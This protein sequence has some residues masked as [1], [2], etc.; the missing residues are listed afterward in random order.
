[1]VNIRKLDNDIKILLPQ[2]FESYFLSYIVFT[3]AFVHEISSIFYCVYFV[4][5]FWAA[6]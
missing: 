2:T 1:M 6:A 4:I 5:G 3:F